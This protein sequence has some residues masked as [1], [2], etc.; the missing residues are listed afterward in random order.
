MLLSY[1]KYFLVKKSCSFR[2]KRQET[3]I[4]SIPKLIFGQ[5]FPY[6]SDRIMRLAD[7]HIPYLVSNVHRLSRLGMANMIQYE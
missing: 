7:L 6:L 1:S 2:G 5:M 3:L 4:C